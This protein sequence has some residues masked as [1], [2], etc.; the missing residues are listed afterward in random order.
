[1]SAPAF[2]EAAQQGARDSA[3]AVAL[4]ALCWE[5]PGQEE[6]KATRKEKN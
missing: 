2:T 6:S 4:F 3:A 5:K 1:M